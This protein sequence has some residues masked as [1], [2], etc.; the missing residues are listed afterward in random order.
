MGLYGIAELWKL[1][2]D[3]IIQI[4]EFFSQNLEFQNKCKNSDFFTK[5]H[6]FIIQNQLKQ[7][8]Y[9]VKAYSMFK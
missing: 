8:K 7:L 9:I 5:M 2:V 6:F 1:E 4:F 3:F